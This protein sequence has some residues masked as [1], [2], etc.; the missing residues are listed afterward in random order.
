M[1]KDYITKVAK[2]VAMFT[3]LFLISFF[4]Y[5]FIDWD[6]NF[7]KALEKLWSNYIREEEFWM[8]CGLAIVGR[9]IIGFLIGVIKMFTDELRSSFQKLQKGKEA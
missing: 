8:V 5:E 9:L 3:G 1:T 7:F 6:G 4:L 2:D